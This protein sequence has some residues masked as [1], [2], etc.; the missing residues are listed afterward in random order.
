MCRQQ[1]SLEQIEQTLELGK[2]Y[3][4]KKFRWLYEARN[5]N[6]SWWAFDERNTLEI[7]EAFKSSKDQISINIAGFTYVIDFAKMQ[8]YRYDLPTR[9]RK[10]KRQE[11]NALSDSLKI[12]GIAGLRVASSSD[13][14]VPSASTESH[15]PVSPSGDDDVTDLC[16]TLTSL[17]LEEEI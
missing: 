11:D 9:I 4:T 16:Q 13:H 14:N 17:E 1:F 7:E 12:K 5:Q 15:S 10:I 3:E 6:D 8:Q 2:D